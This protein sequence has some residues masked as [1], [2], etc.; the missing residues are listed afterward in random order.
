MYTQIR[1]QFEG[2]EVTTPV[3]QLVYFVFVKQVTNHKDISVLRIISSLQ[4]L[5]L[6]SDYFMF[7]LRVI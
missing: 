5:L 3:P 6:S 7:F 1:H 4:T 2:E